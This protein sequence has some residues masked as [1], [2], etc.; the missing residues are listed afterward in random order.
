MEFIYSSA[1][2][3][4]L[5]ENLL[6]GK[7]SNLLWLTANDYP[8][9]AWWIVPA[10]VVAALLCS[11]ETL[12]QRLAHLSALPVDTP[13]AQI[14]MLAAPLRTRIEQLVLPDE[15]AEVLASLDAEPFW[16]VRSSCSDEDSGSASF[17]GQMDSFLFQRGQ[18]QLGHALRRVIASAWSS[19]AIAYR[20][21]KRMPLSG[22]RCAVI[23]QQMVAGEVSGVLFTAHPVSGSRRTM[24]ISAAWGTG[25]GVVSGQCETDEF[26][27]PLHGDEITHHIGHKTTAIVFDQQSGSGTTEIALDDEQADAASLTTQQLLALRDTGARIAQQKRCPQ[28]IE[29]TFRDNQLYL[30]QT[31][32]ITHLPKESIDPADALICDNANIQESYCGITTPLTFSFARAGYATVY[33]Q[34]LRLV[35]CSAK[36]SNARKPITDNMLSL[37]RGRIYYNIQNWYRALLLLPL[38]NMNKSDMEAMMGLE[39]PVDIVQDKKLSLREKIVGAPA[40]LRMAVRVQYAQLTLAP[41]IRQ[42]LKRYEQAQAQVDRDNLHTKSPYELIRLLKYLDREVL[43]RWTA[44]IIN[45]FYVARYNGKVAR[46]LKKFWPEESARISAELLTDDTVLISTEPTR[47]LLAMSQYARARPA[48]MEKI[49]HDSG[50]HL[51]PRLKTF[52]PDF[53]QQC[54]DYIN[55]Y[56]DRTA[57]ELKL[58][59]MTLRQDPAWLFTVLRNY[60][61]S[62]STTTKAKGNAQAAGQ[63]FN[64]LLEQGGKSTLARFKR[65][66]KT[67]RKA[68]RNRETMRFTRTRLFAL[69]RDIYLQLGQQL[70]LE[71][72]IASQRDIFWLT[73]EEIYQAQ[74]GTAIQTCLGPLIEQRRAEYESYREQEEPAHHFFIT[75]T[76]FQQ[77]SC[78]YPY[79]EKRVTTDEAE[80]KGSGCYPGKVQAKVR[81]VFSPEN[82]DDLSGKILCTVRT[83]PGWAP[84]FPGLSGLIVERGSMLSHSAIVAREMGIP[85]IVGVPK[86]TQRLQDGET[87][88]M[89]GTSGSIA[90]LFKPME[91]AHD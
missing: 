87:I 67:L 23:V 84:L 30:L 62:G 66:L 15:L 27:V 77:Q 69:Y 9:P 89:D 6:G 51:L 82:A 52:D 81:V 18:Q 76:L 12:K 8:V 11:D 63:I 72:V 36:E 22:I 74:E 73:R 58:E 49:L 70:A 59:S 7:A 47:K 43:E 10:N 39:D 19:R 65:H 50:A 78:R 80:L 25:E 56:G 71:G 85:A 32:P 21:Q 46:V 26:S 42:F 48:L 55:L 16:A 54:I 31:R 13:L 14:E 41:R 75:Q 45:D 53:Y 1:A 17:A 28:D 3:A 34:T 79:A 44:P 91:P 57:G 35:G 40:M 20:L 2:A 83:D 61:N 24:L 86:V 64:Y 60:L 4:R 88:V 29:W 37:V 33:E 5:N 68:I 38:F 90:R